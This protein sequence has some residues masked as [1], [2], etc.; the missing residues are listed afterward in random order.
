MIVGTLLELYNSG[1]R[2]ETEKRRNRILKVKNFGVVVI[3]GIHGLEARIVFEH[4]DLRFTAVVTD[5]R[6]GD[7][8][9]LIA[10]LVHGADFDLAVFLDLLGAVLR[11]ASLDVELA[12]ENFDGAE[13]TDTRLVA[14]DRGEEIGT[15]FL[16]KILDFFHYGL[17]DDFRVN[18]KKLAI[19]KLYG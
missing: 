19:G 10:F 15:A 17:L 16:D 1:R 13:G 5:E 3:R 14:V 18:I 11:L 4:V 2:A 6:T 7:T 8:Q 9:P 12:L